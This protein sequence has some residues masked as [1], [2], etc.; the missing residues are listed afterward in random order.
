MAE[1]LY[2]GH[3]SYRIVSNEGVVIYVDPY[4]GEG[5]EMPADI[6]IVTHEHSDHNQVDLVTLKDDGVILRH[7][8]L[9]VDGEYL[10]KKIKKVMIE[11]TPAENKNHTREECVGFIMTVD[12]ITLYGAGDTN[13]YLEMESFND[14]DYALLPVDGI[15][16]MSAQEAS[17]CA[18][19]IDSRYFIPIHTSPTQLYDE[20]IAKSFKS[21]HAL[22]IKP[23]ERL[24][25]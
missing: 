10:I 11:G 12:G 21:P 22:Y 24:K 6:V 8:D 3:G 2:Q 18:H 5:Y 23:G 7:G 25:L 9:F 4:A 15:Y 13:Y 17:R 16:N 1:L 20:D 14:L 19:V